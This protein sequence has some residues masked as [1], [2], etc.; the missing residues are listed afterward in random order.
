[1]FANPQNYGSL[2]LQI[3]LFAINYNGSIRMTRSLV[4]R[5]GV[6][7]VLIFNIFFSTRCPKPQPNHCHSACHPFSAIWLGKYLLALY[8]LVWVS[9]C[10]II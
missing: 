2:L 5:G 9:G 1:M 3:L 4:S 7:S 8:E 10:I 6:S